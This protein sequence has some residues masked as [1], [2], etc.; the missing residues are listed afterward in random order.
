[1]FCSPS[2]LFIRSLAINNVQS[3]NT[4]V[5]KLI[6]NEEKNAYYGVKIRNKLEVILCLYFLRPHRR[7][8]CVGA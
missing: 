2:H 5:R 6:F 1:M 7:K 3:D 4:M 8:S